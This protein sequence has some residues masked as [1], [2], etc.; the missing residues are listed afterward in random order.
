MSFK[1]FCCRQQQSFTDLV[2][3]STNW[4]IGKLEKELQILVI[5]KD[6]FFIKQHLARKIKMYKSFLY[7][8]FKQPDFLVA[9]DRHKTADME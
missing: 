8:A 7:F 3:L 6:Q 2:L 9:P 1:I 5:K 4:R